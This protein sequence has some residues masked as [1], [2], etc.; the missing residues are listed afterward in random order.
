MDGGVDGRVESERRDHD[1]EIGVVMI[2]GMRKRARVVRSGASSSL[3]V[4]SSMGYDVR[5]AGSRRIL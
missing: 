4:R 5:L 3:V 1:G 2:F